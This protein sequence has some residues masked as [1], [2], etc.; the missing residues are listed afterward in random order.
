MSQVQYSITQQDHQF[1]VLS[2]EGAGQRLI[3]RSDYHAIPHPLPKL[4]L[5]GPEL[6]AVL[7]NY[8]C[9]LFLLFLFVLGLLTA[10]VR[11]HT[12]AIAWT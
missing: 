7:A 1:F 10:H 9:R 6:P 2:R 11:A 4:S 3:A 12:S 5:R 8:Q